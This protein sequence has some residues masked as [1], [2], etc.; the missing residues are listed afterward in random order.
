MKQI[1]RMFVSILELYDFKGV[2]GFLI[3]YSQFEFLALFL[4]TFLQYLQVFDC[5]KKGFVHQDRIKG[6]FGTFLTAIIDC[7]PRESFD[8]FLGIERLLSDRYVYSYMFYL[9]KKTISD[10]LLELLH[11]LLHH[12]EAFYLDTETLTLTKPFNNE[13]RCIDSLM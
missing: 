8:E 11:I 1:Y 4:L 9:M 10:Y 3:L 13:R 2:P 6:S 7:S 5:M 12:F